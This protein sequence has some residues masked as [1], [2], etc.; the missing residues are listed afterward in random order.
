MQS[1]VKKLKIKLYWEYG[2]SFFSINFNSNPLIFF[3]FGYY[4]KIF[5]LLISKSSKK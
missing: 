5:L 2:A 4:Y 1:D 3:D